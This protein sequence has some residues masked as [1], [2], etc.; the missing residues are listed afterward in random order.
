MVG[1]K[2]ADSDTV[3]TLVDANTLNG[4]RKTAI[5]GPF[6][7]AVVVKNGEVTET[8]T[9]GRLRTR[10]FLD[11]ARAAIG[12]APE[13]QVLFADLAPFTV[14]TWLE[15]P[16]VPRGRTD[17]DSFGLPALTRDRQLITAQIGLTLLLDPERPELLLRTMSNRE[18]ITGN[19]IG[20]MLRDEVLSKVL[21][22]EIEQVDA[23]EIRGNPSLRRTIYDQVKSQL[24]ATLRGYGLQLDNF[25]VAWGLTQEE[26]SAIEARRREE[27]LRR[28][29][30]ERRLRIIYGPGGRGDDSD[31]PEKQKSDWLAA[32][33]FVAVAGAV[34]IG[35]GWLI[36]LAVNS[37]GD[38]GPAGSPP[39]TAVPTAVPTIPPVPTPPPVGSG[40]GSTFVPGV[41]A[42]TVAIVHWATGHLF[43]EDDQENVIGLPAMAD[44]FNA[45]G[46]TTSSGKHIV[47]EPIN[48]PSSLQAEDLLSRATTGIR[49][50]AE[51]C[52]AQPA[53]HPDPTIVTPS[54]AHWL[55]NVNYSANRA[56][57]EPESAR[58]IAR[59]FIGIVTYEDI[60]VCMG[61]PDREIG[62]ADIIALRADPSGWAGYTCADEE[63]KPR[64]E[65]GQKPL[66]A[67]TDPTS[68]STGRSVLL[69]LY[70]MA[71]D[72]SPGDLTLGDVSDPDN[73][74]FVEDFSGL[75][76]HYLIGTTVL[77]TKIHQG[78]RFG[79]FFIMPED[80]LIH[81]KEG[82]VRAFFN[83][84]RATAPALD[85]PM[86]MIYPTE[87]AMARNNCACIVDAEWV[88]DE[89]VE[90]AE[91]WIDFLR[92]DE[93]QRKFMNAGFRPG[94][95][96]SLEG[97]NISAVF[98]LDPDKPTSE[99]DLGLLDPAVA[100]AIDNTWEDV[101][102][103]GIVTF[104]V[105]TSVS[106]KG[107]KLD[108]VKAGMI[109]ALDSMAQSN[110]VGFITFDDTT[111]AGS[112]VAPLIE[113]R[114]D[115]AEAV[116]DLRV[117]GRTALYDAIKTGIEMT[118]AA[119]GEENAIR[120]V[121]VLTDG[122]ANEGDTRLDDL[123]RMSSL[124]EQLITDYSGFPG[125]SGEEEP[126]R[127]ERGQSVAKADV[128][129]IGPL[130]PTDNPI[131][132]FFIGIGD[133]ADL[134]IGRVLVEATGGEFQRV[135][136]DALADVLEE[137]SKYF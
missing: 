131:Q 70:A 98:G 85:R 90:A 84:E 6:Q 104:V 43:F 112:A 65:W 25:Y 58:A 96:L 128:T 89:Q 130:I 35:T 136:E 13:T 57:V 42:D 59:A 40:E 110:Q 38:D 71:A 127:D 50:E 125:P 75:I 36:M 26:S 66:V 9:E 67:F 97:S 132:I 5:V 30:H 41:G 64:A 2:G 15:D 78:P 123:I 14:S 116:G 32:A 16:S 8:M 11:V 87:G 46:I 91:I 61:W 129:G 101:K 95:D 4:L 111:N 106:M 37:G 51:C 55:A 103:P 92:E 108:Q 29:E 77:N 22:V 118:D 117:G 134:D 27:E 33:V 12:L 74:E 107:E 48:N 100:I 45:A 23:S 83:G 73:V 126:P 44:Q 28:A 114:F 137:Y 3:A 121:V 86:V 68:S 17:G 39:P 105:D 63:D 76:D 47:V 52:P 69:A 49:R 34:V 124:S 120:G 93:Q 10:S 79:Q 21:A 113:N 72:K 60:A 102:R 119:V 31:K 62:Y 20:R 109:R 24:D 115:I 88:A 80:N 99:I 1:W 81:L 54:S 82:T 135:A 94:T 7:T 122:K 56:V 133:D 18:S 19:E 53:P